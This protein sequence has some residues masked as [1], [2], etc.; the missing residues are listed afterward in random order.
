MS[1]TL[2]GSSALQCFECGHAITIMFN[3]YPGLQH[4]LFTCLPTILVHACGDF[5]NSYNF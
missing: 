2:N 4:M 5:L 3:F 1:P